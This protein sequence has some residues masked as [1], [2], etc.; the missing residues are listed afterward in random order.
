MENKFLN[1]GVLKKNKYYE[2]GSNKPTLV[3]IINVEG[4]DYSISAWPKEKNG[5]KFL[6]LAVKEHVAKVAKPAKDWGEF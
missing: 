4:K 6:S 2:E 5:D 1:R 3:G